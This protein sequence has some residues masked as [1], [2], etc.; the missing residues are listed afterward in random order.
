MVDACDEEAPLDL[1]EMMLNAQPN[2]ALEELSIVFDL[3]HKSMVDHFCAV[4]EICPAVTELKDEQLHLI[5]LF[6]Q[7]STSRA[8][9]PRK[10]VLL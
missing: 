8:L 4:L 7:R 10:V 9:H 3:L 5:G 2:A 6:L 1:F